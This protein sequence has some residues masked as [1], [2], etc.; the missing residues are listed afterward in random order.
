MAQRAA[1]REWVDFAE[2]ERAAPALHVLAADR[3][4]TI[5][6]AVAAL[7]DY[8]RS[9][10]A[11]PPAAARHDKPEIVD[12]GHRLLPAP[13]LTAAPAA[14]P[15][16]ADIADIAGNTPMTHLSAAPSNSPV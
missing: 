8:W 7:S 9:H 11:A 16:S 2:A 13:R 6:A 14:P 4:R 12:P 5:G 1:V 3:S 15:P 10:G